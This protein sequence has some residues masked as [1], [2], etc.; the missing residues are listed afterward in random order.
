STR[1]TRRIITVPH[2]NNR[3]ERIQT[4]DRILHVR[5]IYERF[6]LNCRKAYYPNKCLTIDEQLVG[7]RGKCPFKVYMANKPDKHGIKIFLLVDSENFYVYSLSIYTGKVS[8]ITEHNQAMHVIEDL[9]ASLRTGHR[10][11]HD[12]FFTSIPE[13]LMLAER[14]H[15]M[16]GTIRKNKRDIPLELISTK[17]REVFSSLF[18]YCDNMTLVS[19]MA[20][21]NLPVFLLTTENISSSV[22]F[23]RRT[24]LLDGRYVPTRH[25]QQRNPEPSGEG[26][27]EAGAAMEEDDEVPSNFRN[28]RRIKDSNGPIAGKEHKHKPFIILE[29][30]RTKGGV[31]TVDQ[32]VKKY[33]PFLKTRRWPFRIMQDLLA[34]AEINAYK[35]YSLKHN[36]NR[37]QEKRWDFLVNLSIDLI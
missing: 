25:F 33:S 24:L 10:I 6:A 15:T 37:K 34:L 29:Y 8:N 1:S 18:A 28:M 5:E 23:N 17:N 30:N 19:Y 16:L 11:T 14:G 32:L 12:N 2:P 26:E 27:T 9:I 13:A 4:V 22:Q 35:L 20:K 3:E 21:K 7:F 31:D 36:L